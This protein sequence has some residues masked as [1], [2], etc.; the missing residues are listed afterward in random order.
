MIYLR[1]SNLF[2]IHQCPA[3]D[4]LSIPL[5]GTERVYYL[6]LDKCWRL[7]L[8]VC[9]LF[10]CANVLD[11]TSL[12]SSQRALRLSHEIYQM[13]VFVVCDF[14]SVWSI[15]PSGTRKD[16]RKGYWVR[17]VVCMLTFSAPPPQRSS[18]P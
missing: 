13:S 18:L 16:A 5:A 10:V 9:M 7:C 17:V 15:S 3:P 11:V 4:S 14:A 1:N 12:P 8:G 6:A 2:D